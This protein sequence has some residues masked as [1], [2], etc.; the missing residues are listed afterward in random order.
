MFHNTKIVRVIRIGR[1]DLC[2]YGE[3]D[4]RNHDRHADI[5][6]A[7]VRGE[8][9]DEKSSSHAKHHTCRFQHWQWQPSDVPRY[10]SA[11]RENKSHRLFV[12]YS[13]LSAFSSPTTL[14]H[15]WTLKKFV[16]WHNR[17][18]S[19]YK[20]YTIA[21]SYFDTINYYYLRYF[22]TFQRYYVK[23][24]I[25]FCFD[26]CFLSKKCRWNLSTNLQELNSWEYNIISLTSLH[27]LAI[28]EIPFYI[29]VYAET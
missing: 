25:I 11:I 26:L 22:T 24:I 10:A 21:C 28:K 16:S 17:R 19:R 15:K 9:K 7:W 27:R 5:V 3:W 14:I 4:G 6:T 13:K 23:I 8:K 20:K 12:V 29:S 2:L 18:M 1:A